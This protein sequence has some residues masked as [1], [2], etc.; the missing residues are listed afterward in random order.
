MRQTHMGLIGTGRVGCALIDALAAADLTLE[1]VASRNPS[2]FAAKRGVTQVSEHALVAECDTVFLTVPDSEVRRVCDALQWRA[3]QSVVHMS[4][5]LGVDVLDHAR[6]L[7]A[8]VG[9]LHPLQSFVL[10]A[11]G[12]RAFAGIT[13]GVDAEAP[14]YAALTALCAKL[15]ANVLDLHGVDRGAYHAAA[16]FASNYVVALHVAAMR[17]FELAGLSTEVARAA[18]APLTL[19]TAHNVAALPLAQALT[20]PVARG[21]VA[22]VERHLAALAGDPH[23]QAAYRVLGRQLLALPLGLSAQAHAALCALLED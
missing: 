12:A 13:C 1:S 4:G 19:N 17:A 22:T 6:A 7:G 14:L 18:L 15:G 21:D 3:G 9:V 16:V 23:L 5:A 11:D 2:A 8:Q 20:G 10:G